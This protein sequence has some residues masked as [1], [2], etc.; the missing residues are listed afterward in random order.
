[1]LM[2]LLLG[3]ACWYGYRQVCA[4]I[5]SAAVNFMKCVAAGDVEVAASFLLDK[6]GGEA[7]LAHL[8]L[9]SRIPI[10]VLPLEMP[11]G[12]VPRIFSALQR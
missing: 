7:E 3:T 12:A 1:M 4:G 8:S 10:P 11:A 6:E 9:S 2:V 5:D